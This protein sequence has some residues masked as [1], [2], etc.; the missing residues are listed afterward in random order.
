SGSTTVRDSTLQLNSNGLITAIPGTLNIGNNA[1]GAGSAVVKLL[2]GGEI[3]NTSTV[4]VASDGLLDLN[5]NSDLIG[6]L[7]V[8]S[9]TNSGAAIPTG[10]GTLTLG[11]DVTL[12]VSGR[13]AVGAS[14]S[15]NLSFGTSAGTIS[16][17]DGAA[18]SDLLVTANI[19]GSDG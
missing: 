3:A 16:V 2:Q 7:T 10:T 12:A 6:A 13:G 9:G 4:V 5:G 14:I 15:G 17:A 18:A 19:S 11:G 1:C 8:Q